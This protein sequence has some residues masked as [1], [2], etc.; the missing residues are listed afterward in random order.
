MD[1]LILARGR[2][3]VADLQQVRGLSHQKYGRGLT[4]WLQGCAGLANPVLQIMLCGGL[5]TTP[6]SR[7]LF[8]NYPVSFSLRYLKN[9]YIR[10]I[11]RH[12]TSVCMSVTGGRRS[13]VREFR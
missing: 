8:V 7:D 5:V 3:I 11:S 12:V 1:H 13:F 9:R 2:L 6:R 10:P 4:P